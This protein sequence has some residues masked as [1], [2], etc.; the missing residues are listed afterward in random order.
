MSDQTSTSKPRGG[1]RPGSGRPSVSEGTT[2]HGGVRL[3]PQH[4]ETARR[5]G[6]GNLS[7]GIRKALDLA[8]D[9]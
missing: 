6:D 7:A 5:L 2:H 4:V 1:R 8:A 9:L 3:T